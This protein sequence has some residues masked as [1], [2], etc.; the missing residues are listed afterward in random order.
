MSLFALVV[1][2]GAL[3]LVV[4]ARRTGGAP[5]LAKLHVKKHILPQL[6]VNLYFRVCVSGVINHNKRFFWGGGWDIDFMLL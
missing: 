2:D 6:S 3:G 4:V 1:L 5:V